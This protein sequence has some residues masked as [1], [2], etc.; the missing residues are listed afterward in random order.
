MLILC[1]MAIIKLK[2]E[3]VT[4]SGSLPAVGSAA[5]D[6][7]LADVELKD[8]S[9]KS[10]RGKNVLM[11]IYPSIDTRVC[12][13]SVREFNKRASSIANAVVLCISKDLPYAQRRFCAAEGINNVIT[14]SDFRNTGFSKDYGVE[15]LN[16]KMAGLHARAIVV[17]DP[18]GKVT[19]TELVPVIGL[20]PDYDRAI[21][22]LSRKR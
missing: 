7:I 11:N 9:L 17:V 14:L 15:M 4:T 12:A 1:T 2:E 20:E 13:M 19:Y 8:V 16:G 18:S 5:P 3:D 21:E 6:F 10:Y 22:A